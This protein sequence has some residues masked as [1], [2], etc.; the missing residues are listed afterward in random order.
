VKVSEEFRDAEALAEFVGLKPTDSNAVAYFKNNYPDF[1]PSEWWDYPHRRDGTRVIDLDS[2]VRRGLVPTLSSEHLK[3]LGRIKEK[4]LIHLQWHLAQEELQRAWKAGFKFKKTSEL[5]DLLRLVFRV[6]RPGLVWN[7][8]VVLADGM[9]HELNTSLYPFH[10]A[11]LYLY[12]HP[13][14]AKICKAEACKKHFVS[15]HGKREF[16]EYTDERGQTCRQK[17]DNERHLDY[18]RVTGKQKRQARSKKSGRNSPSGR[19]R[20]AKRKNL[21]QR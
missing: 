20:R 5:S 13:Q 18:Y 10:R 2:L 9:F 14:Q 3:K 8:S 16:C 12:Q 17:S 19:S 21:R 11:V 1:V 6:N 7:S 15:V 4:E